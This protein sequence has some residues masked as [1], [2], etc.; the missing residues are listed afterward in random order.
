MQHACESSVWVS[1]DPTWSKLVYFC[2]S[3]PPAGN[4]EAST[5]SLPMAMEWQRHGMALPRHS[6]P[7]QCHGMAT[8]WPYQGV[9]MAMPWH[10]DAMA[11]PWQCNGY[12][13]A[14]K[15]HGHVMHCHANTIAWQCH[16]MAMPWQCHG[17]ASCQEFQTNYRS[18][19]VDIDQY[20][21]GTTN[22]LNAGSSQRLPKKGT[23]ELI[24]HAGEFQG[25]ENAC[26]FPC[27]YYH[28][29]RNCRCGYR[30]SGADHSSQ[31]G[32]CG[33]SPLLTGPS[34]F[35][36]FLLLILVLHI[37]HLKSNETHKIH[38]KAHNDRLRTNT[39]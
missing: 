20:S 39:R 26:P 23:I 38:I 17:M 15:C 24:Q 19:L 6:L 21:T 1:M 14:W 36:L 29:R 3:F 32:R 35:V 27:T 10:G 13:M 33:I 28:L 30:P 8:A 11:M 31:T 2:K 37:K 7:W 16:G 5:D 25:I 4:S 34:C 12:A 9:A 18:S 22:C